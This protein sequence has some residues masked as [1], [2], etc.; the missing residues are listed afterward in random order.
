MKLS[1][2]NI[3]Y[4]HLRLHLVHTGCLRIPEENKASG[5]AVQY[6]ELSLILK[7]QDK[8]T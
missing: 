6:T 8:D 7:C 5:K 4:V 3:T 1:S 2:K